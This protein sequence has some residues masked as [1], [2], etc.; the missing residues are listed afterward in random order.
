ME[1]IWKPVKDFEDKYEIS[2][3]GRVKSLNKNKILK[4]SDNGHGYLFVNLCKNNKPQH[5]YI[6]RLVAKHFL[7]NTF[8]FPEINHIN[9]NTYDNR[10]IN[11]EWCTSKYNANYGKRNEKMINL[12]REK[13]GKKVRQYTL[14]GEF[15]KEMYMYEA[16]KLK[17]VYYASLRK[18]C[19]GIYNTCGGYKW[20]Y[21]NE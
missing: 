10:A 7:N 2:N 16:I 19:N 17:N 21:V 18:C 14:D 13:Y 15:I 4:P 1:E 11:L 9:E 12:K 6:H 8:N 20:R 3:L 5:K